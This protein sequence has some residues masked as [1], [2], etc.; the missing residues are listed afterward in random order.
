MARAALEWDMKDLAKA[1]A[2]STNTVARFE[3]GRNEPNQVTLKAMR[4]AFEAAGL[5]FIDA[6]ETA[7]EGVRFKK[8]RKRIRRNHAEGLSAGA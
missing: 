7:G 8:T 4:Q 3:N 1:A 6:D 5:V 2:I